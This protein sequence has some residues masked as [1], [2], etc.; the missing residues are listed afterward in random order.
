MMNQTS[1]WHIDVALVTDASIL[2]DTGL[3]GVSRLVMWF[4]GRRILAGS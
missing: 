3:F 1:G 2:L 4:C